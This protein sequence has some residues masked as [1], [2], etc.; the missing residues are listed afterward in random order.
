MGFNKKIRIGIILAIT[1]VLIV[2]TM[3]PAYAAKLIVLRRTA[4]TQH[5]KGLLIDIRTL[6]RN[7]P[8]PSL[9]DVRAANFTLVGTYVDTGSNTEWNTIAKFVKQVHA[10]GMRAFVM[11][12]PPQLLDY[13]LAPQ[14]VKKAATVGA[15]VVELDEL[16][17]NL[18]FTKD[19]LLSVIDA[20]LA[21][22]RGLQ[23]IVT[24]FEYPNH[25]LSNAFEWTA[26]YP[27]VRVANDDYV[28]ID[29]IDL[30]VQLAQ[31]YQKIPLTW[32]IFSKGS[33][34]YECYL[35]LTDWIAYTQ[36]KNV[37]ALFFFVDPWG[38]WQTQ[39]PLAASF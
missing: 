21:A 36:Q 17:G 37:D 12:G 10:A 22:N 38:D 34:D 13:Q 23:F 1:F 29:Y 24:E 14:W 31:Q 27:S 6:V 8:A 5:E 3:M 9:P 30:E 32:L 2:Q 33:A 35:H 20:G 7:A 26:S 15:D 4:Y 28:T 11:M 18:D 39:W 16:V 19:Q 25:A